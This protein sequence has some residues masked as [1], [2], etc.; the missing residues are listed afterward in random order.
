MANL[1]G[2]T[3][4]LPVGFQFGAYVIGE[5]GRLIGRV[6]QERGIG[7]RFG[8]D[9]YLAALPGLD[10]TQAEAV[11]QRI[12]ETVRAHQ[13]VKSGVA[14]KPGISIGVGAYP[15]NAAGAVQL[16]EVADKELYRAKQTGKNRV[17]RAFVD[18]DSGASPSG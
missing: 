15:E 16:F 13:F 11:A 18:S 17:C 6:I 9:E 14:L 12:L 3:D 7:C 4:T 1:D 2:T 8:G 5:A 10:T